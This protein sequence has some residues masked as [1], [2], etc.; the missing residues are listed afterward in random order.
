MKVVFRT[1]IDAYNN[2]WFPRDFEI[3]P[4]KG[5]MVSVRPSIKAHLEAR[6][7][8][9]RLEVVNVTWGEDTQF[10]NHSSTIVICELWYN[11]TDLKFAQAAG[12]RPL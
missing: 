8:P 4:Q 10:T 1:N 6:K 11:E 12:A 7:L 3:P 9:A 5:H 2:D